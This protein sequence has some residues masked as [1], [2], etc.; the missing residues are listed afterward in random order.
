M[1]RLIGFIATKTWNYLTFQY[2]DF[3]RT[4]WWL[5]QKRVVRTK[6]DIYIL[7]CTILY[8]VFFIIKLLS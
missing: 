4:W 2:L 6:L 1:F 3:E 8:K 5:F 7:I